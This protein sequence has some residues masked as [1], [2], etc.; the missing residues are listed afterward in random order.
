[1]II[2]RTPF[3]ISFLGGGTDYPGWYRQHGGA[4]LASTIDKYCYLSCRYL[5]PFF[6]HRNRVVWSKIESC[7]TLEE[8]THP[9]VREVLK[10]L[11]I[12]RGVEIHHDG[13]LPA[14]SGMGSSS[15][16]TVG[17]L[18]ALYAL[19]GNISS[20]HQLVKES[21]YIEQ[22]ILQE[23]VGSQD[24]VSAA[25]GGFNHITFLPNGEISVRPITISQQRF[26]EFNSYLML[27][28]SGIKRTASD[29]ANSYVNGIDSRK[30]QLRI[31][32]DLVEEGLSIINSGQDLANF[33]EL[34]HEAWQV[35]RSLSEK[36]SNSHIDGLYA[37][38]RAAGAIGG[39]LTGAGGG[40]FLL[41]FVPP[42][43]QKEVQANLNHLIHV[44][45]KLEFSGSQIIFFDR[46]VDYSV[47]ATNRQNDSVAVFQELDTL[48]NGVKTLESTSV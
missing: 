1:M 28:Y 40:G 14:R 27:F 45:F 7:Q 38:A 12:T 36:V 22:E 44:P 20:K 3:R 4:V 9:S 48:E 34:L 30:R 13:D 16:F 42:D 33:G 41:L 15:A 29:V 18:N 6:E 39:K 46:E 32:K 11:D 35:K 25:Y 19:K 17:L 10:Y 43:K 23:T 5:P 2:S 21:I 37:Q 26:E 31:L 8:I 24:Q 47:E